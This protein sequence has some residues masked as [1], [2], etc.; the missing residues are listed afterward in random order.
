MKKLS[1]FI[2]ATFF[3]FYVG[4]VS[5]A[6]AKSVKTI[7]CDTYIWGELRSLGTFYGPTLGQLLQQA[8]AAAIANFGKTGR[9]ICKSPDFNIQS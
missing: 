8:R 2:L 3:A 7:Y 1:I 9:M 4:S 5:A 6:P